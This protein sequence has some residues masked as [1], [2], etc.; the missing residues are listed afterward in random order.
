MTPTM[1]KIALAAAAASVGIALTPVAASAHSASAVISCKDG[2]KI[3]WDYFATSSPSI[4]V[5]YKVTVDG[6]VVKDTT[7]SW[8]V[9]LLQQLN[10]KATST[11]TVPLDT[12][13]DTKSHTVQVFSAWGTSAAPPTSA[14]ENGGSTTV[15][16]KTAAVGPCVTTPPTEP[17]TDPGPDPNPP[18]TPP[19][20]PNLPPV[21]TP[22]TPPSNSV[23][24]VSTPGT[25][26]RACTAVT[27][28]SYKVRARQRNTITVRVKSSSKSRSTVRLRGAGVSASKKVSSSGTVTFRVRPSRRGSIRVTASGC[29]K[30]ASVKVLSAK[31]AERRGTAPSFTG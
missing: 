7:H 20:T 23:V 11:V 27:A 3:T 6:N 25:T 31:K 9:D 18:T 24:A 14:P 21:T 4:T 26:A 8:S 30:V 5:W 28:R 10:G 2:A 1:K 15:P 13:Q 12:I 16:I 17:P 22:T 29:V 19:T